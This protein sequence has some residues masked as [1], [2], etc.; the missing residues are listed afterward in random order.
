MK[1][2]VEDRHI[3]SLIRLPIA[4]I[5]PWFY[6][7]EV[8]KPVFSVF[9]P[10]LFSQYQCLVKFLDFLRVLTYFFRRTLDTFAQRALTTF[11]KRTLASS[12]LF[13][14]VRGFV[15]VRLFPLVTI[16]HQ[17]LFFHRQRKSSVIL[18]KVTL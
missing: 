13:I 10:L 14:K 12:M 9:V 7:L 2:I 4:W 11:I 3:K 17:K 1:L 15:D 16:V 18:G 6:F 8:E 5:L